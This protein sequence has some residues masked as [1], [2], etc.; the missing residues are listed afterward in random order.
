M[1]VEG[2]RLDQPPVTTAL[3]AYF[4]VDPTELCVLDDLSAIVR[5]F[6]TEPAV[7]ALAEPT[8]GHVTAAI[9]AAGVRY[10]DVG[11]TAAMTVHP[12]GWAFAI[13]SPTTALGWLLSPDEPTATRP[14]RALLRLAESV[15]VPV[16]LD[17][18]F[19]HRP[20]APVLLSG[21]VIRLRALAWHPPAAPTGWVAFAPAELLMPI[22]RFARFRGPLPV[23]PR[24]VA[25]V[26]HE[27]ARLPQGAVVIGRTPVATCFR[28]PG[29]PSAELA[30]SLGL[31]AA[32]GRH[33]TWRDAVRV[34]AWDEP[35]LPDAVR[36]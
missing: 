34:W 26:S 31:P 24:Q 33:W 7:V 36:V 28:V 2:S 16:V 14:A 25:F 1:P 23:P 12:D 4:R 20:G 6:V 3:A 30:E 21:A 10:L 11:R 13:N 9:A 15:G 22:R 5:A 8:D 27:P 32:G 19:S 18:R 35:S 29:R 17:E